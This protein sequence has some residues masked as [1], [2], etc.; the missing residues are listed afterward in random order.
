MRGNSATVVAWFF[1][2]C[3]RQWHVSLML[4]CGSNSSA[5]TADR[6]QHPRT[7][8]ECVCEEE[9][10]DP[11]DCWWSMLNPALQHVQPRLQVYHV[12]AQGLH[13]GVRRSHPARRNLR[14]HIQKQMSVCISGPLRASGLQCWGRRQ[15][16]SSQGPCR[17]TV[18]GTDRYMPQHVFVSVTKTGVRTAM[19]GWEADI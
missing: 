7:R 5:L 6:P 14:R 10:A 1:T 17:D 15:P 13:A 4:C 12:A 9:A 8:E 3:R 2:T 19:L 11:E 16:S 18:Q